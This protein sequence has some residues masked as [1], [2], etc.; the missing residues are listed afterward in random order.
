MACKLHPQ[1]PGLSA[2]A[3]ADANLRRNLI[4]SAPPVMRQHRDKESSKPA[5][6]G[7]YPVSPPPEKAPCQAWVGPFRQAHVLALGLGPVSSRS[8]ARTDLV[9][10]GLR[11]KGTAEVRLLCPFFGLTTRQMSHH[12]SCPRERAVGAPKPRGSHHFLLLRVQPLPLG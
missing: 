8:T 12:A 1:P 4:R 6:E 7:G 5:L 2:R 9:S 3:T 10:A 11:V